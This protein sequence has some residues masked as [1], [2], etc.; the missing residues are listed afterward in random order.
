VR[1]YLFCSRARA[2]LV[3]ARAR[4]PRCL[5]RPAPAPSWL[6]D[7]HL[8]AEMHDNNM[9]KGPK[10]LMG[11]CAKSFV[12][13]L[14]RGILVGKRMVDPEKRLPH[15]APEFQSAA[16]KTTTSQ[17]ALDMP[18]AAKCDEDGDSNERRRLLAWNCAC[19]CVKC[20]LK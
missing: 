13:M 3:G 16:S 7:G 9:T 5:R 10:H 17:N 20:I 18:A 8:F 19:V 4:F 14:S 12:G 6:S 2:G 15:C 1:V 11:S